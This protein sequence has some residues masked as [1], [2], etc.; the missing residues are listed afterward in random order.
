[1]PL[2]MKETDDYFSNSMAYFIAASNTSPLTLLRGK[3]LMSKKLSFWRSAMV[4]SSMTSF[5]W[6]PAAALFVL[7]PADRSSSVFLSS[8]I[9]TPLLHMFCCI[10]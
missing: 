8:Y 2:N 10:I 1:M 6:P 3:F 7:A 4:L 9:S 5:S